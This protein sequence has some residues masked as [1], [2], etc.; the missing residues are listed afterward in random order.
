MRYIYDVAYHVYLICWKSLSSET[1][2]RTKTTELHVSECLLQ[3][4]LLYACVIIL[5]HNMHSCFVI[6]IAHIFPDT[7]FH[8]FSP[9]YVKV[10][11]YFPFNL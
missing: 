1:V 9:S 11:S 5:Q 3:S 10:L 2:L 8:F 7:L 4:R 6:M